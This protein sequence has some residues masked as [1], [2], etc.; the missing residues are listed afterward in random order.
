MSSDKAKALATK[1][2]E[3]FQADLSDKASLV[4]AFEG[5]E[6]VFALTNYYDAA[7][8]AD[9]SLEIVQGKNAADAAKEAGVKYFLWR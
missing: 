3:V 9:T 4:R 6:A 7:V 1:G 8:L 2:V 5:A